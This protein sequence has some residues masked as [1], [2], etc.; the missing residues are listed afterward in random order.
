MK[1]NKAQE[2]ILEA[3]DRSLE[4]GSTAFGDS[5]ETLFDFLDHVFEKLS[6]QTGVDF[7]C[8]VDEE[9]LRSEVYLSFGYEYY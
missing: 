2:V 3:V 9:E 6:E 4:A 5:P 7:E 1:L 8:L